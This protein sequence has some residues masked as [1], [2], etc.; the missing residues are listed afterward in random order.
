MSIPLIPLPELIL[1]WSPSLADVHVQFAWVLGCIF[2]L[3]GLYGIG[4]GVLGKHSQ[5]TAKSLIKA[6]FIFLVSG[7]LILLLGILMFTLLP[8]A[9]WCFIVFLLVKGIIILRTNN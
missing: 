7:I 6:G 1:L 4:K 3:T 8:L 5:N 2:Q 9:V